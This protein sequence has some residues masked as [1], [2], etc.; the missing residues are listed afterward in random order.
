[1]SRPFP[2]PGNLVYNGFTFPS[3]FKTDVKVRPIVSSDGR[4]VKYRE[5]SLHV[6][7]VLVSDD[8]QP[9]SNNSLIVP[10]AAG[11]PIDAAAQQIRRLLTTNGKTLQWTNVGIGGD[12]RV[13][14]AGPVS[15]PDRPGGPVGQYADVAFGP[16]V[17]GFNWVSLGNNRA[18][19]LTWDVVVT[20]ACEVDPTLNDFGE[21]CWGVTFSIGESGLTVRTLT[22]S[23][24]T[25]VHRIGPGGRQ[26]D[27]TADKLR[28]QIRFPLMQGFTRDQ[29]WAI[30][31][32]KRRLDFQIV[33]RE[34]P[35][36]NPLWPGCVKMDVRH[37]VSL[38]G[39]TGKGGGF[40]LWNNI[41]SGTIELA[42]GVNRGVAW[43]A[44]LTIL[45][46]RMGAA[47]G[48]AGVPDKTQGICYVGPMAIEESLFTRQM[49][50]NVAWTLVSKFAN[51][52][53]ASG[54]W[55]PVPGDW[56]KWLSSMGDP[57]NVGQLQPQSVYGP[58]GMA[59]LTHQ[60]N[61][62]VIVDFC[63]PFASTPAA[64]NT[65]I[66]E[67]A[68]YKAL[69]PPCP[70]PEDASWLTYRVG[71]RILRETGTVV[72]RACGAGD[73]LNATTISA[74]PPDSAPSFSIGAPSSTLAATVVQETGASLM[75]AEL[76]GYAVRVGRRI[77]PPVLVSIGGNPAVLKRDDVSDNDLVAYAGD[78]PVYAMQWTRTYHVYQ[79]QGAIQ[80]DGIPARFQDT[81]VSNS[82]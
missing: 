49:S 31:P 37:R 78:C 18:A 57:N 32:D 58:L 17:E 47:G 27:N 59:A 44:F 4:I 55:R 20:L 25:S 69:Q 50:F 38:N 46:D 28:P 66:K 52:L 5:Y 61:D 1:M 82:P 30:S 21:F 48:F 71:V 9:P 40:R 2:N 76:S 75:A 19:L 62:D 70:P 10:L 14:A 12:L 6:E 8:F 43:V 42:P 26:I 74:V 73:S 33:D 72:H 7:S 53:Q 13:S 56:G 11:Q 63:L 64:V 35:S 36:E 79:P 68:V 81:P 80:I 77:T 45:Q 65:P 23:A 16:R 3:A 67:S 60:A 29:N 34:L 51:I 41:L 54:L 22:G 24:E 15:P 39:I